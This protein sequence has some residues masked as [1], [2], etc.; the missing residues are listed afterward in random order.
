MK[1]LITA[2]LIAVLTPTF[3]AA[4]TP[5]F[6]RVTLTAQASDEV[7]NDRMIVRF[8]AETEQ[9]T[10]AQVANEINRVMGEA[11]DA[12]KAYPELDAATGNYSIHPVYVTAKFDNSRRIGHWRGSQ[13]LRLEGTRMQDMA[14][15][16]ETLQGILVIKNMEF[17]VSRKLRE[18]T[19]DRLMKVAIARFKQRAELAAKALGHEGF[20]LVELGIGHPGHMPQPLRTMAMDKAMVRSAAPLATQPGS[21]DVVVTV[22][23]TVE[24][25]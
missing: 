25:N 5:H 20:R 1:T 7:E 14:K 15:L 13:E 3:G 8:A 12:L 6:N 21:S 11:H 23:G 19:R 10:A 22:S 24:L 2:L 16:T 18:Q 4:E 9:N 17:T